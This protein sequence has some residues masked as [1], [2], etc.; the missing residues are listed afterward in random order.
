MDA[1]DIVVSVFL[2]L[3]LFGG[4]AAGLIQY[5]QSSRQKFKLDMAKQKTRQ[6]EAEAKRLEQENQRR[7]LEIRQAELEIERF[8]RR[9]PGQPYTPQLP[10]PGPTGERMLDDPSYVDV[11]DPGAVE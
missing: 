4:S 3:F 9:I 11:G 10:E 5:L 6:A 1:E 2:F 8:D 7:A